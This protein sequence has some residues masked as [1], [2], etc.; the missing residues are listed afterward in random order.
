MF[1]KTIF[2]NTLNINYKTMNINFIIL[3]L[4]NNYC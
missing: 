1:D 3:Y 4:K 2:N